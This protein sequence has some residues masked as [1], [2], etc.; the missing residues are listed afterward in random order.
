M[1]GSG[2]EGLIWPHVGHW[3]GPLCHLPI[4]E[5][6]KIVISILLLH[7]FIEAPF[8]LAFKV[9]SQARWHI[10][11]S[12]SFPLNFAPS[13]LGF[14]HGNEGAQFHWCGNGKL[15]HQGLVEPKLS[16]T[17]R[18]CEG[19]NSVRLIGGR[20]QIQT[21]ALLGAVGSPCLHLDFTSEIAT[22]LLGNGSG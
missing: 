22:A 13:F 12:I 1:D 21:T 2:V 19:S 20:I 3:L 5:T 7:V 4:R 17:S 16:K 9:S 15:I 14:N 11:F 10:S 18:R 8:T 6:P